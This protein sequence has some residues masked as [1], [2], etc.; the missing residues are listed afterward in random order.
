MKNKKFSLIIT[1][2]IILIFSISGI[3]HFLE[4]DYSSNDVLLSYQENKLKKFSNIP[5]K[6][7]IVGDSAAGNAIDAIYFSSLSKQ[8]TINL[9]LSGS[10]GLIGSLNMI[11]KAIKEHKEIKNILIIQTP[12]I[13]R[14]A[15]PLTSYFKTRSDELYKSSK[16]IDNIYSKYISF[17]FNTK[18]IK[19]FLKNLKNDKKYNIE[20]D[21]I[22]QSSK[23]FSNGKKH[24]D[25][26][27]TLEKNVHNDKINELIFLDKFCL[28]KNLNCIF[29]HAPIHE[30]LLNNSKDARKNINDSIIKNA[31][32]ITFI[33]S[34]YYL[35]ANKVGDSED[36]VDTKYKSESTKALY[37]KSKKY[38]K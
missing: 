31:K 35:Q 17:I 27:E 8:A 24:L 32:N 7:I 4:I 2:F 38:L 23:K 34:Y 30:D 25:I 3:L 22:K 9:S 15:L 26:N 12:D 16:L 20:N 5:I 36:H 13:W 1:S 29:M 21:Y 33:P 28:E 11:K 14:R 10:Y 37:T 19:W 18:E 6:T